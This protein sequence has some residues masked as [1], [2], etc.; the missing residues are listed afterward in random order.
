[1]KKLLLVLLVIPLL[2]LVGLAFILLPAHWQIRQVQPDLPGHEQLAEAL[3]VAGGPLSISYLNSASQTS[4]GGTLGHPGILIEWPGNRHFLIDTGM[5]PEQARAFAKPIEQLLDAEPPVIYGALHEQLGAATD[6]ITGIAFT[7]LHSDHTDGLPGIC[8][9][10]AKPA[11]VFQTPLQRNELNYTTEMGLDALEIAACQWVELGE[12]TIKTVPGFPGLLA[13]SLGGH[14][15]G[16]TL[17]AVRV[18]GHNWLFSGD[19]TNDKRSVLENL[20]K[21]WLY[22]ALIVPED[23]ARTE[24]LR[25]WLRELD[26]QP[27]TTV[28]PAHDV[29]AMAANGMPLWTDDGS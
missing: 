27:S 4:P 6:S 16:S 18:Q 28:L 13:V 24:Q 9:S 7:H 19:I 2:G 23:T 21:E 20:P 1:M 3:E 10:Q 5:P 12:A 25:L 15:P 26:A 17:Y 29:L 11:T 14:T 22:S 8:A